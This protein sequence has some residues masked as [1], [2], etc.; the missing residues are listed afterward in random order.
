MPEE[1]YGYWL[2]RH[3]KLGSKLDRACGEV[4]ILTGATKVAR[5]SSGQ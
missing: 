2:L 4:F 1:P 5:I 3:P